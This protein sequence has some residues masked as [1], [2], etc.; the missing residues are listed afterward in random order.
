MN[1][2]TQQ[3]LAERA[4]LGFAQAIDGHPWLT[5]QDLA[6]DIETGQAFIWH[7]QHCDVFVRIAA[8]AVELGPVCGDVEEMV[9]S[10]RP[11]IEGWARD[12][13][14]RELHIQAGR[15]GWSRLLRRHGYDE[16]AVI[17]RKKLGPIE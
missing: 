16:A 3:E 14:F 1:G 2:V 10:V 5:T 12:N 15:N 11:A 8:E 9:A 7:G 13:G 6:R 4:F 17:L